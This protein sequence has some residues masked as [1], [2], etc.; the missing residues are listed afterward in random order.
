L[1]FTGGDYADGGPH[2]RCVLRKRG[3]KASFFF[4]GDFYRDPQRI[5]IRAH[6]W[7]AALGPAVLV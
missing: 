1:V 3:V 4:T 7:I 2:I 6:R 5:R